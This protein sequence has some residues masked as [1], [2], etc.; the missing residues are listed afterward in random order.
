MIKCDRCEERA[1]YHGDTTRLCREHFMQ[2]QFE[3]KDKQIDSL[4]ANLAE[5]VAKECKCENNTSVNHDVI[6]RN[7]KYKEQIKLLLGCVEFYMHETTD[8]IAVKARKTLDE[9]KEMQNGAI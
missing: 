1:W 2:F 4:R 3:E 5:S 8:I 9:Y 7:L 6:D